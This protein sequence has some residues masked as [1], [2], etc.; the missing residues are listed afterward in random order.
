MIGPQ[1]GFAWLAAVL[2]DARLTGQHHD[3]VIGHVPVGE[4]YVPGGHVGLA[5]VPALRRGY[6]SRPRAE[7]RVQQ[8]AR[9]V[10]PQALDH[11]FRHPGQIL[12]RN[13]GREHQTHRLRRQAARHEPE[14]LRRG[15]IEPLL[16]I[17]EA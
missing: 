14:N 4:Q 9:I 16:V 6:Q 11:Q 8:R 12:T 15:A 2:D 17:D 13:P 7:H 3:Q 5:A 10:L 1:P